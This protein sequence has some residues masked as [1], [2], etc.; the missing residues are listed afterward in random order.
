MLIDGIV[1]PRTSVVS[2]MTLERLTDFPSDP[3]KGQS[4]FLTETV[5]DFDPGQYTYGGT[6]W[7]AGSGANPYA[8]AKE[9]VR[10]ATTEW[11]SHNMQWRR[12]SVH[13]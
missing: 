10:V 12:N 3:V 13:E 11:V 4:F 8:D 6:E 1:L 7:S 9:S 5:G 2:G